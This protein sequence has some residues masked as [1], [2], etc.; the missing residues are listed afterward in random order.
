MLFN[1]GA[2]GKKRPSLKTYSRVK[3]MSF[4]NPSTGD[5]MSKITRI[6]A[7]SVIA[8]LLGAGVSC[9]IA[10]DNKPDKTQG[11][12][13]SN[14][15]VMQFPLAAQIPQMAGYELRGR[16]IT[17]A[18]GGA[19]TEHSHATRPGMVYILE[20]SMTEHR[21][22]AARVVKAGDSWAEDANTVHWFRNTTDKPCVFWAVDVVKK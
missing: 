9:A 10:A 1:G 16:R 13:G 12:E 19:V 17:V 22:D 5:R 20:G 7:A 8:V 21:G 4:R 18:P 15:A 3:R 6:T 14:T 2:A 11:M